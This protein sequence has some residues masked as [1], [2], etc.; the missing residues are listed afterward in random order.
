MSPHDFQL[1]LPTDELPADDRTRLERLRSWILDDAAAWLGSMT[2]HL[3]VLLFV[4]LF[5]GGSVVESITGDAPVFESGGPEEF[6][7]TVLEPFQVGDAPLDP[8]ELTTE[9]LTLTEP[10]GQAQQEAVHYDESPVFEERGGGTPT[11]SPTGAGG[12]GFDI[13]ADGLGPVLSGGGGAEPGLGTGTGFGKGGPGEGFGGRGKGHREALVGRYG[14]TKQTERAVAAALNWLARHQFPNGS[15]SIRR[16]PPSCKGRTCQGLGNVEADAG[17]TALGLLP[18]LAAGQTHKSSGPYQQHISK[19]VRWLLQNQ[20]PNGDLSLGESQM[21]S[22]ALATIALCET[23][24]MTNDPRVRQAAYLAVRFIETGQNQEGGWRYQHG[25]S[26]ADTSV[27]GWQMMAL[28]SAMMAGVP[29]D[30]ARFQSGKKWLDNV[31][32]RAQSSSSLGRFGYRPG[33]PAT[34]CMSAVALLILQYAG[35]RP[36]DPV[37][38]GGIEYL[39]ANPPDSED[40]DVYSWYYATQVLHNMCGPEWDTWNRRM[41]RV[42]IESQV[43]EGCAAGSW[44]PD[45]DRWGALGGRLMVTSLSALTLE[46]YYRYLPLYQLDEEIGARVKA[47]AEEKASGTKAGKDDA[48]R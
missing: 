33:Q 28:K 18:F 39:M 6:T 3:F 19:A 21:Y 4:G 22:H 14:G 2:L 41:R 24:G 34:P 31:A 29:V 5:F 1:P 13:Q 12:L 45:G 23:C 26:D 35:A 46:V 27:F 47:R 15:W 43:K 36:K 8:T 40:R 17:A 32:E 48:D 30:E 7:E 16:Y 10:P 9:S 42:L 25:T 38:T 44:G 37:M 20:K 11:G